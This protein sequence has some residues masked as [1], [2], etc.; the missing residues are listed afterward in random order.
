MT[1]CF[2]VAG[3]SDHGFYVYSPCFIREMQRANAYE[4]L[5]GV[6]VKAG[7]DTLVYIAW[8]KPHGRP[9]A[10]PQQRESQGVMGGTF[11]R[12]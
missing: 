9:F 3:C 8:Q 7:A 10:N 4:V 6:E 12:G 2:P 1:H 5:A 11:K